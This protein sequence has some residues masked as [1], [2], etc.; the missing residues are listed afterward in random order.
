[1]IQIKK[2]YLKNHCHSVLVMAIELVNS[3]HVNSRNSFFFPE[4]VT[5]NY[6]SLFFTN[7]SAIYSENKTKVKFKETVE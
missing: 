2:Y 5:V 1:M 7:L 6:D 4:P 3:F